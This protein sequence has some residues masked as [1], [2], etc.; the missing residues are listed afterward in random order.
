M[1]TKETQKRILDKA[2]ELFNAH[3]TANVSANRIADECGLSRGN[4]YYHFNS[5]AMIIQA[6]YD[7]IATEVK[8]NWVGDLDNPTIGHMLEMF[9]RQLGLIWQYRFFYRELMA[10]LDGDRQLQQRFG[11]DR[12]ERTKVIV[13]FFAVLIDRNVLLGPGNRK[14]LENLVKLSWILSDNWINY[15]SVDTPD[16]YPDC[17]S[18][19]YELLIDLFRP[20]LTPAT[21]ETLDRHGISSA[22]RAHLTI[23]PNR[24]Q[25]NRS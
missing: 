18:E 9:D 25:L 24:M 13:D 23:V 14:T 20:Y 11:Y 4:L 19:G 7:R 3:G 6:I 12:N 2:I 22:G 5:K 8:C 17:V 21:L 16:V 1:A 10:L 15:I